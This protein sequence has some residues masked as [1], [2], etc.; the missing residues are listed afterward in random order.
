[1]HKLTTCF[2][3]TDLARAPA[4]IHLPRGGGTLAVVAA[5]VSSG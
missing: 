2:A 1:M 4:D 3:E 5:A